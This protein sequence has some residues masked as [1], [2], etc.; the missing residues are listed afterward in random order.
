MINSINEFISKLIEFCKEDE[1]AIHINNYC[2]LYSS[3]HNLLSDMLKLQNIINNDNKVMISWYN[4]EIEF[5][6]NIYNAYFLK[7]YKYYNNLLNWYS[8]VVDDLKFDYKNRSK[9]IISS[10]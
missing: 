8:M 3:Y 7:N 9:I 10:I 5:Y 6:Y 1:K 2:Y 4:K